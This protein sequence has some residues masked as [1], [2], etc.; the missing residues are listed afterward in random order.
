MKEMDGLILKI[1]T[2]QPVA[3]KRTR[4]KKREVVNDLKLYFNNDTRE[5]IETYQKT[6]NIPERNELY[7]RVIL[8]AFEKLVE[9][10]YKE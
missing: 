1:G 2:A 3:K 6:S 4:K 5:A 7:V 10:F 8:P 9:N